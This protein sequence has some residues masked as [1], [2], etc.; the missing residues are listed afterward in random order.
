MSD[1]LFWAA[2]CS[3]TWFMVGGWHPFGNTVETITKNLPTPQIPSG[4]PYRINFVSEDR[5]EDFDKPFILRI[6]ENLNGLLNERISRFE[7]YDQ[8][9][10]ALDLFRRTLPYVFLLQLV[11]ERC[12]DEPDCTWMLAKKQS[13]G[14]WIYFT[15]S[16]PKLAIP[17]LKD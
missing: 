14:G 17:F 8:A 12:P 13:S 3:V 2:W 1:I 15:F 11:E 16:E 5:Q 10:D 9:V 7:T 4:N 6:Q